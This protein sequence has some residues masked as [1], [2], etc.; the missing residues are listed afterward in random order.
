MEIK[1]SGFGFQEN[2][3]INYITIKGQQ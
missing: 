2:Q 1:S 3:N